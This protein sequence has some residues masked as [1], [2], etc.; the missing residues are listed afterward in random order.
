MSSEELLIE[1]V[2]DHGTEVKAVDAKVIADNLNKFISLVQQLDLTSQ[3]GLE[4]DEV[5]I[6][7]KISATGEVILLNGSQGSGNGVIV[8]KFKRSMP[9]NN[10]PATVSRLSLQEDFKS[11][12]GI[13]YTRLN[14]LLAEG[15]WQKANQETWDLLCEALNKN[16]GSYLSEVEI[17]QLPC[18]DIRTIDM[19]WQKHSQGRFGFT[20]QHQA[21]NAAMTEQ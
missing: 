16:K 18:E 19:L 3:G 5:A 13:D 20:S 15:H 11:D 21:Y 8:L 1:I 2:N 6:A 12:A 9:K 17:H 4:L 10:S 14:T 7:T